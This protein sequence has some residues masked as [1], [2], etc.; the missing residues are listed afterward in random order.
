MKRNDI[1]K[2]LIKKIRSINDIQSE[3]QGSMKKI[4]IK[5]SENIKNELKKRGQE[6][7]ITNEI[8]KNKVVFTVRSKVEQVDLKNA[9]I[10]EIQKVKSLLGLVPIELFNQ[11]TSKN[12]VSEK[13]LSNAEKQTQQYVEK[14]MDSILKTI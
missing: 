14:Q 6:A 10:K 3:V 9:P 2:D 5:G 4:A 12:S 7:T 1:S 13:A 8:N 11:E